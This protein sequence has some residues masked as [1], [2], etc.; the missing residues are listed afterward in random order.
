MEMCLSLTSTEDHRLRVKTVSTR[1]LILQIAP[2]PDKMITEQGEELQ[3]A[4]SAEKCF[5]EEKETTNRT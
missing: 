3:T 2:L 4:V 5:R 1:D